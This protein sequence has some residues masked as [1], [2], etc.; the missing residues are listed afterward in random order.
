MARLTSTSLFFS[1]GN[2]ITSKRWIYPSGTVKLFYQASAPTGW[3]KSLTHNDKALRVVSGTGGGSGG[4]T[5]L[6]SAFVNFSVSGPFSTSDGTGP[7]TLNASQIPGHTHDNGG[8]I[9]LSINPLNPD[10]SYSGGDVAAG[11]GWSRNSPGT[12]NVNNPVAVTGLHAHP[13]S[14]SGTTPAQPIN[15]NVNYVDTIICSYNG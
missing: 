10:G 3:T 4:T 6:S 9:N 8:E 5:V 2:E 7:T 11:G 14:S 1:T 15:L 13:F 12:G